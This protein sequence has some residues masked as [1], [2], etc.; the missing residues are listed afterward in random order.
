MSICFIIIVQIS[1]IEHRS[2]ITGFGI[3]FIILSHS[4]VIGLFVWDVICFILYHEEWFSQIGILHLL[5]LY[6]TEDKDYGFFVLRI[7]KPILNI[8][9]ISLGIMGLYVYMAGSLSHTNSFWICLAVFI[10]SVSPFA[11][12][13][14]SFVL[15]GI[16]DRIKTEWFKKH[17]LNLCSNLVSIFLVL[18]LPLTSHDKTQF[19]FGA[20][21][22]YLLH[23]VLYI[24][25]SLIL[26][27]CF[28]HDSHSDW[29]L[30]IIYNFS[31]VLWFIN[32]SYTLEC[33]CFLSP[34]MKTKQYLTAF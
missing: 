7:F 5:E 26:L 16:L 13:V 34:I 3:T 30:S 18:Y 21:I 11:F 9:E 17:M 2:I 28:S 23:L 19:G 8:F 4:D 6:T 15:I 33:V 22:F 20:H 14:I 32:F 10:L 29:Q 25:I 31:S 24:I 1:D 27:K 12:S